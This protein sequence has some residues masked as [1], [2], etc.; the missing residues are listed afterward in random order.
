MVTFETSQFPISWLK[1][2]ADSNT[3]AM[4]VTLEVSQ[5]EIFPLK[6][7]ADSNIALMF[8]TFDTSQEFKSWLNLLAE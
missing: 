6:T 3:L 1:R 8:V 4:L 7:S 5:E 2:D